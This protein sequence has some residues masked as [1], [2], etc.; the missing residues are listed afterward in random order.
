MLSILAIASQL[1]ERMKKKE[2]AFTS[3]RTALSES[4]DVLATTVPSADEKK[5]KAAIETVHTNYLALE[6]VFD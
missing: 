4:V 2:A 5:I 6:K 1:P 3:A